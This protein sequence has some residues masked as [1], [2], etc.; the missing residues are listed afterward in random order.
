MWKTWTLAA[1]LMLGGSVAAG[2]AREVLGV[3]PQPTEASANNPWPKEWERGFW[4][5]ARHAAASWKDKKLGGGTFGEN[6]KNYYPTAMWAYFVGDRKAA[7]R[8]LQEPDHVKADHAYTNNVDFYWCFT[9]K[10]QMR[11]Y[12]YF[13]KT[14]GVLDADYLRTFKDGAT[15]WLASDPLTTD[16]PVHGKGSGAREGWGPEVKGRR[17]D[18]RNTDNLRAM[19]DVSI[20]LMAEEVGA[21]AIRD[22]YAG[23]IRRYVATLY[24]V[25][26][27]EWDSPNYHGHTLSAYHNL[28]D[29]A[30]DP[31]MKLVGKAALDWLYAAAALKY[32]WGGFAGPNARDYG[33]HRVF[34]PNVIDPLWLYFDDTPRAPDSS[35]RDD[36]HHLTSSYRP[37]AAVVELARKNFARPVEL[38]ASKP[39]Y[40]NWDGKRQPPEFYETTYIGNSF[41]LGTVVS[42]GTGGPWNINSFGMVARH[43]T[44]GADYVVAS[45]RSILGHMSKQPGDQ[46][47]QY[48]NVVLWLRPADGTPMLLQL[49]RSAKIS[50]EGGVMFVELENTWLAIRPINLGAFVASTDDK[51]PD[52]LVHTAAPVGAGYCGFALEVGEAQSHGDAARFRRAILERSALDLRNLGGGVV[53]YRGTDDRRLELRHNARNELPVVLRDGVQVDYSKR[54]DV[55]APADGTAPIRQPSMAG[56]LRVEA[57]GQVFEGRFDETSGYRF[58]NQPTPPTP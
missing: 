43:S 48:R 57:G 19:R 47:A 23:K 31:R 46:V 1:L 16:H 15:R 37:P 29:F 7:L 27:S 3:D 2:D 18:G 51:N 32:A 55:Y 45:S 39:P 22:Q 8:A 28:Y 33:G 49:P 30:A 12:F 13:G 24:N 17:V 54:N 34:A 41:Q 21:D 25:G 40:R 4:D 58:L 56:V 38:F 14:L 52:D 20:Y 50:L 42:E 36:I 44:R 35:D 6:E 53:A 10:G 11:K 5:R 9:L 26:M